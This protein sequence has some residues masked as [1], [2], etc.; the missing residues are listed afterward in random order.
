MKALRK[1]KPELHKDWIK[2][3]LER[4]YDPMYEYQLAKK[5]DRLSFSGT[6]SEVRAWITAFFEN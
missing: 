2:I 5:I 3:V 1:K 4:Y 6:S